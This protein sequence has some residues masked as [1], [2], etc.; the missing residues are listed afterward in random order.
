[1]EQYNKHHQSAETKESILCKL[2]IIKR[3]D[4]N[5]KN[6]D[7]YMYPLGFKGS[8]CRSVTPKSTESSS[9]LMLLVSSFE[10]SMVTDLTSPFLT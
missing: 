1:M 5:F 7:F 6:Y 8:V 3:Q 10:V 2:W 4:S 9:S